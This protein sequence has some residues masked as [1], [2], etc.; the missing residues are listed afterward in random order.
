[1]TDFKY[2][3]TIA[4]L[5]GLVSCPLQVQAVEL[6]GEF[7]VKG[8]YSDVRFDTGEQINDDFNKE[9]ADREDVG[10]L[11]LKY[12]TDKYFIKGAHT[13]KASSDIYSGVGSEGEFDGELLT[14]SL[15]SRNYEIEFGYKAFAN[16]YVT[17]SPIAGLREYK[18]TIGATLS[19]LEFLNSV[20]ESSDRWAE[21]FF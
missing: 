13:R 18:T 2:A 19:G 12:E 11:E 1:M 5:A 8:E 4:L 9:K 3:I 7:T 20:L 14:G 6:E 15:K 10:S 21:V 16:D 17:L